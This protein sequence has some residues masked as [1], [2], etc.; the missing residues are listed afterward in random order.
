[1]QDLE[2]DIRDW[3]TRWN[4]DPKLYVWTKPPKRSFERIIRYLNR[5]PEDK[6]GLDKVPVARQDLLVPVIDTL[7]HLAASAGDQRWKFRT[8]PGGR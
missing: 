4:A 3:I 6:R 5:I 7:F 8:W 1:M 2:D